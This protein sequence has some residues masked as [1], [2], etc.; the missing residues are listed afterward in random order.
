MGDATLTIPPPIPVACP[1]FAFLALP[2]GAECCSHLD[3]VD[4]GQQLELGHPIDA[5]DAIEQGAIQP[6]PVQVVGQAEAVVHPRDAHHPPDGLGVPPG[7]PPRQLAVAL[8]LLHLQSPGWVCPTPH[9]WGGGE[10]AFRLMYVISQDVPLRQKPRFRTRRVGLP[11]AG[12]GGGGEGGGG[13]E[14]ISDFGRNYPT[15]CRRNPDR[16]PDLLPR[17]TQLYGCNRLVWTL[18]LLY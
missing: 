15:V 10:G 9:T 3:T 5:H 14:Q 13:E 18:C 17:N 7:Q 12:G 11:Q 1:P 6:S 4:G 2:N 8:R 16:C